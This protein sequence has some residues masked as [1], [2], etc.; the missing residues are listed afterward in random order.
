MMTDP[1]ADMLTRIRNAVAV[2][3]EKVEMPLSKLREGV[4]RILVSE[5]FIDR[6]ETGGEGIHH[7]LTLILRYGPK[8]A[9]AIAGLRRISR[10]GHRVYRQASEIPRV[11]GGLG[12]SVVSTSR[13][14]MADRDA[15]RRSLGG[16]ILCEVW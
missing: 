6:Y 10:P 14:L 16:E 5:G 15:R 1:I 8:R 4:A 11:Q 7:N 13:G 12:V 3:H 9:P 2:G